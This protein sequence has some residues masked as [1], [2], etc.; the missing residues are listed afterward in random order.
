MVKFDFERWFKDTFG[1]NASQTMYDKYK[2]LRWYI[3]SHGDLEFEGDSLFI[4][5]V[6]VKKYI[7]ENEYEQWSLTDK[8]RLMNNFLEWIDFMSHDLGRSE[9]N[10]TQMLRKLI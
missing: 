3:N 9:Q 10:I 1:T 4:N 2:G 6:D 5:A 7:Y 8:T